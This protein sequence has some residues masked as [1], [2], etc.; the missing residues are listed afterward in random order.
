MKLFRTTDPDINFSLYFYFWVCE[1]DSE[2]ISKNIDQSAL[3]LASTIN[4]PAFYCYA[5]NKAQYD[6]V[7]EMLRVLFTTNDEEIYK[8]GILMYEQILQALN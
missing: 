3:Y 2:I 8:C 4:Y 6:A 5:G 1:I 7:S